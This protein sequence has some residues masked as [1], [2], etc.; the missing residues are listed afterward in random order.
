MEVASKEP[1]GSIYQFK[2][3]HL[4]SLQLRKNFDE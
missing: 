1:S 4:K 2:W 3:K